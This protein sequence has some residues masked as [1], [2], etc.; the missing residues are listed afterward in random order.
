MIRTVAA[1]LLAFTALA[2]PAATAQASTATKVYDIGHCTA[3]GQDAYCF[4]GGGNINRPAQIWMNVHASPNQKVDV[5]WFV[6]CFKG[7]SDSSR[8]G[9][10][11]AMTPVTSRRLPLPDVDPSSCIANAGVS[12]HVFGAKGSITAWLTAT[13]R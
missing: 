12:L 1:S 2:V 13:K 7:T 4:T 8:D 9:S 5:D 10:F 11:T 6:D 3:T